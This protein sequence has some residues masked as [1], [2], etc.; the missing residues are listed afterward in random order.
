M[1]T[2]DTRYLTKNQKRDHDQVVD[3]KSTTRGALRA[4]L[5]YVKT[6]RDGITGKTNQK[7]VSHVEALHTALCAA[8]RSKSGKTRRLAIQSR[9]QLPPDLAGCENVIGMRPMTIS[10]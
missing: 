6:V 8:L 1:Q 5:A 9:L 4:R 10:K 2:P 7:V 3:S